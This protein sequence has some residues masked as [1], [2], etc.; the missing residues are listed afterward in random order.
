MVKELILLSFIMGLL[1]FM[2][3]FID[4]AKADVIISVAVKNAEVKDSSTTTTK[5][6][7]SITTIR[8]NCNKHGN[9]CTQTQGTVTSSH[10]DPSVTQDLGSDGLATGIQMQYV[11][12]ASNIVLGIGV[13]QDKTGTASL[14]YRFQ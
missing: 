2:I 6:Q 13:F 12:P 7:D 14:G 4:A 5:H 10:L 3:F 11:H 1:A 9:H 8:R